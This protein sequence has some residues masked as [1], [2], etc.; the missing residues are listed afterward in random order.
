MSLAVGIALLIVFAALAL[1]CAV[2]V[3]LR[4]ASDAAETYWFA[5]L[6]LASQLG[7]LSFLLSAFGALTPAPFLGLQAL[8]AAAVFYSCPHVGWSFR[9]LKLPSRTS[10][11]LICALAGVLAFSLLQQIL[12]SR[13]DGDARMYHASRVAYWLQHQSLFPWTTHNDRQVVFGFGSELF[14]FW[15]VLFTRADLLGFVMSWIALPLSTVGIYFTT[16]EFKLS[17]LAGLAAALF[18]TCTP[19]VLE[20][21]HNMK[22]EPWVAAFGLGVLFW[23]L[24]SVSRP[25]SAPRCFFLASFF[26][27]LAVNA[28]FYAAPALVLVLIFA[29]VPFQ[30]RRLR[31]ALAGAVVAFVLS[32]L[33][34]PVVSNLKHYH[35]PFGSASFRAHHSAELSLNQIR[36]HLI[37][38]PVLLFDPPWIPSPGL[39]DSIQAGGRALLEVSGAATLPHENPASQSRYFRYQ[40]FTY[41]VGYSLGGM[42]WLPLLAAALLLALRRRDRGIFYAA[43]LASAS[44]FSVVLLLRWGMFFDVPMR[45]MLCAYALSVPLGAALLGRV[46]SAR[47]RIWVAALLLAAVTVIPSCGLVLRALRGFWIHPDPEVTS[48]R[49]HWRNAIPYLPPGSRILVFARSNAADYDLFLPKLGYPN[50][51]VSWGKE[52][53]SPDRFNQLAEQHRITHVVIQ[54]DQLL[55]FGWDPPLPM[56][57]VVQWLSTNPEYRT[58]AGIQ[59]PVRVFRAQSTVSP[60]PGPTTP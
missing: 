60:S 22:P 25:D 3:A 58:I 23:L 40:T 1:Y 45:F 48:N 17:R 11:L 27:I 6:G 42:L 24:R 56:A 54:D 9:S 37:R 7:G 52:P 13:I 41:A 5:L 55:K 46:P 53:F 50:Y 38:L 59:S 51:V 29:S 26:A 39:R 35:H 12:V 10:M 19:H 16:R 36:V 2:T 44:L 4:F 33:A 18:F 30:W 34:V 28:K 49:E 15:P 57:D 21:A 43:I 20:Q 47:L 14:F 8:L 32:G 31:A